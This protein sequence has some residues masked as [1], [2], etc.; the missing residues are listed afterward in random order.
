MG[1]MKDDI[2]P[3]RPKCYQPLQEQQQIWAAALEAAAAL[4]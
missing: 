4:Q 3:Q 2:Q 1:S